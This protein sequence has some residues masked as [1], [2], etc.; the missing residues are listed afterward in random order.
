MWKILVT[1]T[2]LHAEQV[3]E[4]YSSN[5]I[6]CNFL[7]VKLLQKFKIWYASL[8]S[9]YRSEDEDVL[10][11]TTGQA[12]LRPALGTFCGTDRSQVLRKRR[13]DQ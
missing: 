7:R 4:E 2:S 12:R 8:L 9:E 10:Q 3:R 13:Q 11:A 5:E 6:N 1:M